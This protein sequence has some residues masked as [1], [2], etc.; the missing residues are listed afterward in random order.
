[1][2]VAAA[3]CMPVCAY[4]APTRQRMKMAATAITENHAMLPCPRGATMKAARSGPS[5]DPALP[6]V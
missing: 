1:M 4:Q 6:P 3:R 5:D 2:T